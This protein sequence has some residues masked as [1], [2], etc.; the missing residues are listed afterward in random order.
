[1]GTS[2]RT[3][4]TSRRE[5]HDASAFYDRRLAAATFS[6]DDTVADVPRRNL[7]RIYRPR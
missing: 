7:D 3:F 4:G 5:G 1:M 6:D 2:T